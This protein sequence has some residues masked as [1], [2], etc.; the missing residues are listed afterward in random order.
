MKL[1]T[2]LG[3]TRTNARSDGVELGLGFFRGYVASAARARGNGVVSNL[4][5]FKSVAANPRIHHRLFSGEAPKKKS[6]L[7]FLL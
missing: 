5:D 6:K 4:P 7:G 1:G 2:L 3:A